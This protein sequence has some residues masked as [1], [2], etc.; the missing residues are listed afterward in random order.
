M[1]I[2]ELLHLMVDKGASDLHLRVMRP[3]ILRIDGDLKVMEEMPHVTP[4]DLKEAFERLTNE[5]QKQRFRNEL[6]L[7]LAYSIRGLAR[8]RIN[9]FMQRDTIS[10]AIRRVPFKVPTVDELDLPGICKT[11]ALKPR[12]LVLVT[13]RTGTGKSTTLAAMIDH[14]NR[15]EARNIIT[16]EDPIEYVFQD[17]KSM[18]AQRDLG[19]DTKSFANALRHVLRQDPDVILV[20]E[21]RDLETIATAITAA[22][23]GHLVLSTLHTPSAPQ[24][25]DRIIDVFPPHQ[26]EQI[27][28]QLSLVLEGVLSQVLLRR[29]SERGRV[30]A[31]EIMLG[32]DAIRNIIRE[33]KIEQMPTYMQTGSQFGMQ[34]MDQALQNL[35][36]SRT[37][38]VEEALPYCSKPEELL[39]RPILCR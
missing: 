31:V 15:S 26:Q 39:G 20:G 18:I 2:E 3:P 33:G 6:E 9:A 38:T 35:V 7:D 29:A 19:S 1:K 17:E 11:L 28:L 27:R 8:F 12:G 36:K 34:T 10:L 21:M 13:G 16:V 32:N 14:I 22:E 23:T 37:V 24:A 4:S 25:I 5:N 30:A